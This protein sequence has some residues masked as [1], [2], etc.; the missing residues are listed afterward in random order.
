MTQYAKKWLQQNAKGKVKVKSGDYLIESMA[1]KVIKQTVALKNKKEREVTGQFVV[2]GENFVAEIPEDWKVARYLFSQSYAQTVDL[3]RY[4]EKADVYVVK[5]SVFKAMSDTVTPQGIL[6]V[7]VQKQFVLEDMIAMSD[8]NPFLLICEKISDPGNLGTLIRTADASGCH[9]VILSEGSVDAYNPKT[10][11]AT[12][13][14]VFHLPILENA[15]L[16]DVI[17]ALKQRNINMI[18]AHLKGKTL[19]YDINMREGCAFL[20]GNEAKGLSPAVTAEANCL[21]KIPIV[22]KAESLNASVASSILLYEVVRQ[23]I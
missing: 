4:E 13:G 23:R 17:S 20:I 11:R 12:A 7:C 10:I 8:K 16:P 22:G 9:G 14:S 3:H 15:E 18:A 21:V 2:E 1:N 5:D 19:P 6:A